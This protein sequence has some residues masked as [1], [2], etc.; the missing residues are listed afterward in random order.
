MAQA[1]RKQRVARA[2]QK[3]KSSQTEAAA[4]DTEE[5]LSP[6]PELMRRAIAMG[7][8]GF[9]STE[10]AVRKAFGDTIPKD[11][12]D[13]LL[14]TSDR[15]RSEFLERVSREIGRVLEGVDV[16]SVVN[17]LLEGRSLQVSAEF[18]LTE[19][20]TEGKTAVR[21]TNASEKGDG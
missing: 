16:A 4:A 17:Q 12:T 5:T 11:W 18:R 9:F 7:L 8:S 6:I 3:K 2:D 10:E 20:G 13:F 21:F 19:K 1:R 15:T 14:D